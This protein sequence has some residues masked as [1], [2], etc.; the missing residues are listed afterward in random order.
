M[1]LARVLAASLSSPGGI[2]IIVIA[3]VAVAIAVRAYIRQSWR[4]RNEAEKPGEDG[5]A[6]RFLHEDD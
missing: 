1:I 3:V 5:P 2:T 4:A 6:Q